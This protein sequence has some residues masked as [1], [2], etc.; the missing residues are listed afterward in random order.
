MTVK[1]RLKDCSRVKETKETRQLN[2]THDTEQD[3]VAMEN[4]IRT[5]GETEE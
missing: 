2:A 5:I 1:N 3:F 4:I